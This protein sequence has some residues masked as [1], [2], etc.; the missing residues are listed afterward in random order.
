M[1][2]DVA[3]C[4]GRGMGQPIDVTD[5]RSSKFSYSICTFVTNHSQY[6]DMVDS[7][8]S[9]GF[10]YD[11]CEY[12][13]ID[14]SETNR[15]DAFAGLNKFL[16]VATGLY[17]IICHQDVLLLEDGR[18]KLDA[19]IE[20][21]SQLDPNW[22][23]CGNGGGVHPGRLAL[24]VTDP[25]GDNQY[26]ER[27]PMKVSGLDENFL[28]ARRDANLAV[29]RDLRGF[30]LYGAD[31][32]IVARFLGYTTYVVDFHIRHLSW[33]KKGASFDPL[34]SSMIAKYGRSLRPQMITTPSTTIFL[35][36]PTLLSAFLNHSIV[37]RIARRLGQ[38]AARQDSQ[39]KS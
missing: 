25:H 13:Y 24:R 19:V 30:H 18:K 22:G 3:F 38:L 7:F 23:V 4:K 32:C 17:I 15:Y 37:T 35:G 8:V 16:T 14:N 36:R 5:S 11:D 21:L 10:L 33:G 28:V 2:G 31:L 20:E 6:N 26:T 27:L 29:S 1:P 9:H 34:R 12:L 39:S